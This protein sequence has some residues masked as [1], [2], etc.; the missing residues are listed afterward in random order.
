MFISLWRPVRIYGLGYT[1][2][3]ERCLIQGHHIE[4]KHLN[5]LQCTQRHDTTPVPIAQTFR[6]P[7]GH[8]L[9]QVIHNETTQWLKVMESPREI[10]HWTILN[11]ICEFSSSF[12]ELDSRSKRSSWESRTSLDKLTFGTISEIRC[13]NLKS[14][15]SDV[16]IKK[17]SLNHNKHPTCHERMCNSSPCQLFRGSGTML[18]LSTSPYFFSSPWDQ[19]QESSRPSSLSKTQLYWSFC[20]ALANLITRTDGW[21]CRPQGLHIPFTGSGIS[22]ALLEAYAMLSCGKLVSIFEPSQEAWMPRS[23]IPKFQSH[24]PQ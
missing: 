7:T 1:S 23:I 15:K 6:P 5:L 12:V 21:N 8:V 18:Q 9:G 2:A 4:Y 22:F 14:L 19:N 11:F 16:K 17:I 10:K 3:F 20:S 13:P 24:I